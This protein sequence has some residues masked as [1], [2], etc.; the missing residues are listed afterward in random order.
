[1]KVNE[2]F[3]KITLDLLFIFIFIFFTSESS[4]LTIWILGS[5]KLVAIDTST[6]QAYLKPSV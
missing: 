1:M 6:W 5:N 4:N 2:S 3:M